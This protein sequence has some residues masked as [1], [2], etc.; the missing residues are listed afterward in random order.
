MYKLK[1]RFLEAV[2]DGEAR[3]VSLRR[4][5]GGNI[6]TRPADEGFLA[7]LAFVE[8]ERLENIAPGS[9]QKWKVRATR[10]AVEYTAGQLVYS[11]GLRDDNIAE[12][13][14]TLRVELKDEELVFTSQVENGTD[15]YITDFE[16]PRIGEVKTLGDGVPTLFVP[17]QS[18]HAYADPGARVSGS[19]SREQEANTMDFVYPGPIAMQWLA[20]CGRRNCLFL[21]GNDATFSACVFRVRGR[22]DG[23]G[24]M[25]LVYDRLVS[26]NP[27]STVA[28]CPVKLKFY[29]G[30]WRRGAAEYA[31]WIR[32]YRPQHRRP[33]WVMDMQGYYLVINKQQ[34]GYEMWPYDTLPELFRHARECGCDTLGL[35]GWYESGHDNRYPDLQ[36]SRTLGGASAL[37]RNIRLVQKAG[38]HVT[39]YYQG[40]LIDPNSDF[41]QR[42]GGRST[43]RTVWGQEYVEYYNKSHRSP[44]LM[45]FSHKR[46]AL[47]CPASEKWRDL[48]VSR[49]DWLAS[50]G[51]DGALYDQLGG[52][53]P[54]ICFG[55]NHRHDGDSP[56]RAQS[57]G[58]RKLLAALQTHAKEI[59]PEF[60][61]ATEHIT[62]IYSASADFLHGIQTAPS[63][64][65]I[66]AR[67]RENP[68]LGGKYIVPQIFRS[69]F[70]EVKITIRNP[71]PY[72]SRRSVNFAFVHS[73]LFEQELRYRAD[74]DDTRGGTHA[75]EHAYAR[76][77]ADFRRKHW[78][79][80]GRGTY[81]D[82]KFA[83]SGEPSLFAVSYETE[84]A[85]AV[86]LW[87]DS[88]K[89]AELSEL[90]F[91]PGVE[92]AGYLTADGKRRR[93]LPVRLAADSVAL[94]L[95]K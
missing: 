11:D 34:F 37:K 42:D 23:A 25:T 71:R 74:R 76:S 73:F 1:N 36:V 4:T 59:S 8:K 40:H 12:C 89:P 14:I 57:G 26:V 55:K 5:D 54:Y 45:H 68:G 7:V 35:F 84:N 22:Q 19:D 65:G 56:A 88:A 15:A 17:E 82:T 77:I 18:G 87:N 70:P 78:D 51:A 72:M 44:F 49:E 67:V 21:E 16:Y 80:L 63:P 13:K 41:Y 86:A 30:D 79:I 39:L 95:L 58:R 29:E 2:F 46:F 10:K 31:A 64:Q 27:R 48:M 93:K 69:C 28:H 6:L 43:L 92:V 94:L 52:V 81:V 47:A 60:G 91:A 83:T 38:G 20:L 9:R 33:Q 90:R 3:L 61:F 50:F 32:P 24:A 66:E 75:A 85:R 53:R 62:D